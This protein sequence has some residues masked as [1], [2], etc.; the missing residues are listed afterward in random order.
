VIFNAL[1]Q[2]IMFN[3]HAYKLQCVFDQS[4]KFP[5]RDHLQTGQVFRWKCFNHSKTRHFCLALS[6]LGHFNS[7]H[8]ALTIWKPYKSRYCIKFYPRFNS[9]LNFEC[10][11]PCIAGLINTFKNY[12]LLC[13]QKTTDPQW[14]SNV[15]KYLFDKSEFHQWKAKKP[16]KYDKFSSTTK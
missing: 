12:T 2:L 1:N 16:W 7:S 5:Y 15:S 4:L 6:W 9:S 8:L 13:Y 3:R 14:F 11:P 10:L